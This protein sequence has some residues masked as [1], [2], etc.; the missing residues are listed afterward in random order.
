MARY[1]GIDAHAATCT[2]AVVGPSGKHL[3]CHVVETRANL[4]VDQLKMIA[5]PRYLCLEEGT[6]SAWLYEILSPL[7]D[8]ITVAGVRK[9][10]GSKN[11]QRDAFGLADDLIYYVRKSSR[12][13]R[14][15]GGLV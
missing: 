7:V 5:R 6:Q 8:H 13:A 11:D 2:I 10:R 4:L 1:I 15:L 14:N 12:G 9:K 3:G